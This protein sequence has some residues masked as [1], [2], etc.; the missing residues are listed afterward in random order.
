MK[1]RMWLSFAF[2]LCLLGSR[3]QAQQ[4]EEL[5]WQEGVITH[6]ESSEWGTVTV[7]ASGT[8]VVVRLLKW[9]Y[10]VETDKMVYVLGRRSSKPLDVTV[11]GKVKFAIDKNFK[12]QLVDDRGKTF[13]LSVTR[14]IA[15]NAE[16]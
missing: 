4:D 2:L 12:V 15:K 6:V 11:K 10:T 3:L 5:N 14:K 1:T 7:P 13:Q 16:P 9:C 8:V